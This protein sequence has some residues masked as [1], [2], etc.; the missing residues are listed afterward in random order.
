MKSKMLGESTSKVEVT[1]VSAF[2]I[3]IIVDETE[4]FMSYSEFPWFKDAK[5]SDILNVQLINDIHLYWKELDIDIEIASLKN[6][7]KYP[8]TFR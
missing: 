6:L 8:L 4:Y 3:W 5:I 2:G 1:N 7:E